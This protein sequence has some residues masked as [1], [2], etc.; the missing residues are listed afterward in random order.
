MPYKFYTVDVFTKYPFGGNPLAVF[1][2]STGL[3][4]EQMQQ[5]A[6]E[7]NLSET[8][9]VFPPDNSGH[10]RQLR[11]FTPKT[12]LPFAGHPTIGAAYLLALIGEIA[13]DREKTNIILEETVGPIAVTIKS[14]NGT[15]Q[16]AKLTA[17]QAPQWGPPPPFREELA[18]IL[19]LDSSDLLDQP[20]QPQAIS[21]GLPFLLIPLRD[22]E[23]LQRAEVND[24]QWKTKLASFWAPHLYLLTWD[25][26]LD[27]ADLRTRMFAPAMGVT[28]DPATGAAAT[29][30]AAY[31]A[32]QDPASSKQ[33]SWLVEQGFEMGRPS[34]LEVEAEKDNH[35]I[36][37][38]RVGG[39]SVLM[40][41][42][43]LYLPEN[44]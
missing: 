7:L 26:E 9:F 18:A 38:I 16:S 41:E 36:A 27:G 1:P 40:S 4:T 43:M 34:L 11:I 21:C 12:E 6:N 39:A 33:F 8:V 42:G 5:I 15:P 22:R 44:H 24:A 31:L 28:E 3:T 20:W 2:N 13:I 14:Q 10:T 30:L 23:A 17:V 35:E 29:T 37:S 32:K 19:S 25:P